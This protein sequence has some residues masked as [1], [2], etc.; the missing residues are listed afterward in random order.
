MSAT[1][2]SV[3]LRADN[4]APIQGISQNLILGNTGHFF[5]KH[6]FIF[7]KLGHLTWPTTDISASVRDLSGVLSSRPFQAK[8]LLARTRQKSHNVISLASGGQK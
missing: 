5:C 1:L 7:F 6:I 8:Q 2:T 4:Q 3:C